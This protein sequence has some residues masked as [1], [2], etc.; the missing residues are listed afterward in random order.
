MSQHNNTEHPEE[1]YR[2]IIAGTNSLRALTI[3]DV[4]SIETDAK[5]R[6]IPNS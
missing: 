6:R 5:K 2:I 3:D 1:N 4:I